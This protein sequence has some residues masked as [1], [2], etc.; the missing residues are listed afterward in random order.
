V[1]KAQENKLAPCRTD[2]LL[3]TT[4]ISANFKSPDTKTRKN[5]KNPVQ[6]YLDI[7]P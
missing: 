1:H 4:D 2:D 6:S 7:V 5:I 3:F